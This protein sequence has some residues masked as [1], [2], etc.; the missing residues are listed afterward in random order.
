MAYVKL[1]QS[2]L[3]GNNLI[4]RTKLIPIRENIISQ[5][6]SAPRGTVFYYDFSEI[7]GINGS[8]VD[9]II[10]KVVKHLISEED[11]FL[12]LKNLQEDVYEHRYNID[13]F[14]KNRSKIGVVE[15]TTGG[16][17][18]LGD[19]SEKHKDLLNYIYIHKETTARNIADEFG[20]SLTLI[21]T[22]LNALY[23]NRLIQRFEENLEEGGRQFIYKSL[24]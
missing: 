20:K 3:D 23:K 22:H 15:K 8:G 11:K 17:G 2:D 9:E 4:V 19:V 5:I 1:N 21:S 6:N 10:S 18:F 7:Q 24:F 16:F 13:S 14:L 12:F